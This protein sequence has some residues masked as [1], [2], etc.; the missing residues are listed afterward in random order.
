MQMTEWWNRGDPAVV[1]SCGGSGTMAGGQPVLMEETGD[2]YHS[3]IG[4]SV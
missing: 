4:R 2:E 1:E 3:G